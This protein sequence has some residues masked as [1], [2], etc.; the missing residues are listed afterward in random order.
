[1]DAYGSVVSAFRASGDLTKDKR[2]ILSDLGNALSVG[3]DRHKTEG[4]RALN[5][6]EL[7]TVAKR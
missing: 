5:D 3:A 6:E 4:R 7:A 1:M 2:K